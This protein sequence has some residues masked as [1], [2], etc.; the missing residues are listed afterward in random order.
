MGNPLKKDTTYI[1]Q[2]STKKQTLR[3][4]KRQFRADS[5][6]QHSPAQ[7]SE[8][9][10]ICNIITK[11]N[12]HSEVEG[13]DETIIG[14][15]ISIP[16]MK[17]AA[18]SHHSADNRKLNDLSM[19]AFSPGLSSTPK[20]NNSIPVD[21]SSKTVFSGLQRQ[22][23]FNRKLISTNEYLSN[24]KYRAEDITE[25]QK[26]M[27][28]HTFSSMPT[29]DVLSQDVHSQ[30]VP[31]A[32]VDNI[33]P[34]MKIKKEEMYSTTVSTENIYQVPNTMIAY[35]YNEATDNLCPMQI[36]VLDENVSTYEPLENIPK[37]DD[38]QHCQ[39]HNKQKI[40]QK[41][42]VKRK[43]RQSACKWR[44]IRHKIQCR[45]AKPSS[46]RSRGKVSNQSTNSCLL[47]KEK[48]LCKADEDYKP[49][50][51]IQNGKCI[52]FSNK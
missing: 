38:Q 12:G 35:I 36:I 50:A 43:Y 20:K 33:L 28:E 15:N 6:I 30:F 18:S 17:S 1:Y 2:E 49:P 3:E 29:C 41:Q 21:E 27:I 23:I 13:F 11:S 39:I 24:P 42:P 32:T 45:P 22:E 31:V 10:N 34:T 9:Q 47:M 14:L 5:N 52:K 40:S 19:C 8:Y 48:R 46:V 25:S 16:N 51:C 26:L 7:H 44:S 37:D 4:I